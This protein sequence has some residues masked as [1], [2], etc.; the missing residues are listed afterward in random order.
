MMRK[1]VL[2][3]FAA[4]LPLVAAAPAA[5]DPGAPHG[6]PVYLALGDSVPAGIGAVPRVSGYPEL[7]AAQLDRDYNPAADKATG[8]SL[9]DVEL[10]NLAVPGATTATLIERQLAPALALIEAR[11][12]DSDPKND[13]EVVTV[14]IG[15]ND[16]FSPVIA[17]CIATPAPTGCQATVDT[18]LA[19]VEQRLTAILGPLV[20]VAGRDTE[21][22][23]TTYYNPI[24]SC[25]LTGLNPAAPAIADV[26]LEGGTLPGLVSLQAGLNDVVREVAGA[27]GA[28]V[29]DLYGELDAPQYVGGRDCLHPNAAG[30]Q[31]ITRELY[32]TLAR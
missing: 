24:G 8:Q 26:V 6:S 29:T 23:V 9:T 16:L 13:V 22:V 18:A 20:A 14:T 30:H 28:Q 3:G 27:T 11:D 12:G 10:V 21:V 4:L 1:R 2:V 15:G 25:F 5:A 31:V 19:G 32:A 17:A 7:L